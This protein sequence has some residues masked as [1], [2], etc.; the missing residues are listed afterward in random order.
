MA[1][2]PHRLATFRCTHSRLR[3][4]KEGSVMAVNG[5]GPLIGE[6]TEVFVL[7][8]APHTAALTGDP[9]NVFEGEGERLAAGFTV[10][11]EHGGLGAIPGHRLVVV[12]VGRG[13]E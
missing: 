12:L 9:W 2:Q 6:Y 8:D 13:S 10:H 4:E 1:T 5:P 3:N 7:P 11:E